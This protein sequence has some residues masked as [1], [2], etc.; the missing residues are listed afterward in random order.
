MRSC[1]HLV[2]QVVE[3]LAVLQPALVAE[4]SHASLRTARSVSSRN[5]AIWG[6]VRSWPRKFTVIAP[7]DL[8]VLLLELGQLGLAGNIR[9]P[10]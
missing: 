4:S 2:E 7:I 10:K 5:G 8:L 9:L 6:S 3:R 1:F